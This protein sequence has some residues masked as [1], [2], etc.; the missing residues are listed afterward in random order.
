MVIV[1]R[2]A[3]SDSR[4]MMSWASLFDTVCVC[5][6]RERTWKQK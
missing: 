5:V 4:V 6:G 1:G 3:E 2:T